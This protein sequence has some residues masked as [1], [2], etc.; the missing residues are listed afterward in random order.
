MQDSSRRKPAQPAPYARKI[1]G[2]PL[3]LVLYSGTSRKLSE[4]KIQ[5]LPRYCAATIGD[6]RF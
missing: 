5:F 3:E 6:Q 1:S 4:Q 2:L